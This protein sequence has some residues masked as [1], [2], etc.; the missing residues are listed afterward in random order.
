MAGTDIVLI[1]TMEEYS[2]SGTGYLV[3]LFF[4]FWTIFDEP[5]RQRETVPGTNNKN[6]TNFF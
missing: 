3:N 2:S 1:R 5:L 6:I 4:F